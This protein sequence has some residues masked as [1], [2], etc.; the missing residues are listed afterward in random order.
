MI[1]DIGKLFGLSSLQTNE[2]SEERRLHRSMSRLLI[3]VTVLWIVA[4]TYGVSA[5]LM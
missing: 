4:L 3:G 5:M 1:K 2:I